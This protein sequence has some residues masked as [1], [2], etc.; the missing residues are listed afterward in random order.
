MEQR[1]SLIMLGVTGLAQSRRFYE[2][3]L[4]WHPSSASTEQVACFQTGGMGLALYGKRVLAQ[5][6]HLASARR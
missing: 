4:R 6:A 5:D 2:D 1:I 3:S